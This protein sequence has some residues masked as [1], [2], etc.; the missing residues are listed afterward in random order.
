[1]YEECS[2]ALRRARL[3]PWQKSYLFQHGLGVLRGDASGLTRSQMSRKDFRGTAPG[4]VCFKRRPAAAQAL[5]ARLRLA[6][7]YPATTPPTPK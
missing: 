6:R 1:M 5:A 7:R 2:R 3:P 4:A